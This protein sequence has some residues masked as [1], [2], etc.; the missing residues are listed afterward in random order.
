VPLPSR[1]TTTSLARSYETRIL[2]SSRFGFA[3]GIYDRYTRLVRFGARDYDAETGRWTARDPLLFAG[4]DTNLYGYVGNNPISFIDPTGEIGVGPVILALGLLAGSYM[5][6]RIVDSWSNLTNK[7]PFQ[8]VTQVTDPAVDLDAFAEARWQEIIEA[9]KA[10]AEAARNSPGTS[11]SGPPPT[12]WEDLIAS[13]ALDLLIEI[14][15]QLD[16]DHPP[17]VDKETL[18]EWWQRHSPHICGWSP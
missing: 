1:W 7:A 11:Y 15:S 16:P 4:G 12:S 10:G 13:G 14:L 9:W 3:G 8:D 6:Y 5:V 2:A 17:D 18:Q